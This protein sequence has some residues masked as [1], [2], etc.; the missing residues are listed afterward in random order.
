MSETIEKCPACD[1]AR[2]VCRPHGAPSTPTDQH[3]NTPPTPCPSC[4]PGPVY[5]P[6]GDQNYSDVPDPDLDLDADTA[7]MFANFEAELAGLDDGVNVRPVTELSDRELL[8]RIDDIRQRL[9]ELG[10]MQ[11][12]NPT[13]DEARDLHSERAALLIEQ[14]RRGLAGR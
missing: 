4:N 9:Y 12:N 14:S 1:G 11:A 5:A 6:P 13:T 8:E 3:C 2:W 7:E 10:E